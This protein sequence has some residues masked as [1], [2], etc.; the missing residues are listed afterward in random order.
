RPWLPKRER[1]AFVT[2]TPPGPRPPQSRFLGSPSYCLTYAPFSPATTFKGQGM[3]RWDHRWPHEQ[4]RTIH[5]TPETPDRARSL[6]AGSGEGGY[7]RS[8]PFNVCSLV[9]IDGALPPRSEL[10]RPIQDGGRQVSLRFE[11][12]GK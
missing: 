8:R 6:A 1:R 3:N 4:G 2:P 11:R 10:L 7:P 12:R 9:H 5:R